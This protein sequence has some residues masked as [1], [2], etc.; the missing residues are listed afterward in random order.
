M[1]R[2][3]SLDL[4]PRFPKSSEPNGNP[5]DRRRPVIVEGG[6]APAEPTEA[7]VAQVGATASGSGYDLN[8]ENTPVANVAKVILGDIL[9]VG[10]T[11]DPRV[12]GTVSLASGRPVPRS[13]LL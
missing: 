3:R 11:I 8:F 7:A 10:Y 2:V 5:S 9:H 13:D 12:Q 1:D 6:R 4:S